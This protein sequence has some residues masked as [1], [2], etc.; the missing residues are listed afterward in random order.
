MPSAR[1]HV[2]CP[3]YF[4]PKH[5]IPLNRFTPRRLNICRKSSSRLSSAVHSFYLQS[6]YLMSGI[7]AITN[8]LATNFS[9]IPGRMHL[10]K[11]DRNTM[12]A[13]IASQD[14]LTGETIRLRMIYVYISRNSAVQ[15]EMLMDIKRKYSIM[16]G[17]M[18]RTCELIFEYQDL[19]Q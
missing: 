7:S 2:I 19:F 3:W 6:S 4:F 16:R 8:E 9:N 13:L 11:N 15:D 17:L 1:S 5:Q 10:S 14:I 12:K 18:E